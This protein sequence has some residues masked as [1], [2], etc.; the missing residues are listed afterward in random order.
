MKLY[1]IKEAHLKIAALQ[2]LQKFQTAYFNYCNEAV[3]LG[4]K[5][6]IDVSIFAKTSPEHVE[7]ELSLKILKQYQ[8][9]QKED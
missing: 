2:K 1:D 8:D 7:F 9:S 6:V 3:I 4:E 5:E